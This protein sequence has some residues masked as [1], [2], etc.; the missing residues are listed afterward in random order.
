MTDV[1]THMLNRSWQWQ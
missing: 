1:Y